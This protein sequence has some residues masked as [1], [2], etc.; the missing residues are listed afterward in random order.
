M[1]KKVF[2]FLLIFQIGW[3]IGFYSFKYSI[4]PVQQI[5][6]FKHSIQYKL[7]DHISYA[8]GLNNDTKGKTSVPCSKFAQ[9]RTPVILTFG[10][11]NA[12]NHGRGLFTPDSG[13]YNFNFLDGKCYVGK[14]PLLGATGK[15][16]SVWTRLGDKLV[17]NK[18][19]M[20]VLFVPIAVGGTTIRRWIPGEPDFK[21]ISRAVKQLQKNRLQITHLLWHQGEADYKLLKQHYKEYFFLMLQGIRD[22]NVDAPIFVSIASVCNNGGSD[23]IRAA[24]RELPS[25][26][27]EI[28]P[29]P[30]T[31]TLWERYDGCHLTEIGLIKFADLWYDKILA[32]KKAQSS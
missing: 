13:V 18:I 9:S 22:L 14:D 1:V 32:W 5:R 28:F 26:S 15:G 30:N 10:Q 23:D 3:I 24:Q 16:A 21:N 25:L 19:Y 8:S 31:D 7:E 6:Y 17:Q 29:G 2:I 12:A 27:E 11:S 4:F 20:D